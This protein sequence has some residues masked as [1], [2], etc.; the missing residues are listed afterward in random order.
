VELLLGVQP[1]NASINRRTETVN[2]ERTLDKRYP[3][4]SCTTSCTAS[5]SRPKE[6][7]GP[8]SSEGRPF[9]D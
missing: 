9:G 2:P 7:A 1:T 4:N 3:V 5:N 8:R 6:K